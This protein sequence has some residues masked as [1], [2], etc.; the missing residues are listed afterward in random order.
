MDGADAGDL[1]E[2]LGEA[3][4]VAEVEGFDDEINVDGFVIGGAGLD[5]FDVGAVFGDDGGEFL[6]QAGAVVDDDD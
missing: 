1:A 2:V 4:E 3:G 5:G 6:E